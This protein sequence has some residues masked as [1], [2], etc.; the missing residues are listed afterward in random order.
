MLVVDMEFYL[1]LPVVHEPLLR[2]EL[3]Y[4]QVLLSWA[5]LIARGHSFVDKFSCKQM[6]NQS[7]HDVLVY[8]TT[9]RQE[10]ALRKV[11]EEGWAM[12]EGAQSH[13]REDHV[14]NSRQLQ[15]SSISSGKDKT[16]L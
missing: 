8:T 14:C 5:T 13:G 9:S 10:E 12:I 11:Y 7:E 1:F 15:V 16:R 2:L 3:H 4:E 6:D